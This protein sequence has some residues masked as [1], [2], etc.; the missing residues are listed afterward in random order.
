MTIADGGASGRPV[1]PRL[2]GT[3]LD[4]PPAHDPD[5]G[6][7]GDTRILGVTVSCRRSPLSR[8][9]AW[10]LNGINRSSTLLRLRPAVYI[11]FKLMA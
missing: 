1:R 2:Y 3:V 6:S 5:L 4:Q 9:P 8:V 7:G 10:Q 11:C